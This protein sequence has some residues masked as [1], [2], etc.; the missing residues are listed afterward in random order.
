MADFLK[1]APA[2][3]PPPPTEAD[4]HRGLAGSTSNHNDE[5]GRGSHP[6][7]LASDEE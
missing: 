3:S 2:G 5:L 6:G 7:L 1:N 4:S